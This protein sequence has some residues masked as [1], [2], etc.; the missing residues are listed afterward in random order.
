MDFKEVFNEVTTENG[1]KAFKTTSNALVDFNFKVSSYRE[2]YNDCYITDFRKAFSENPKNAIR[3]LFYLRDV[4]GGIGERK[5]FRDI[6][7]DVLKNHVVDYD[8]ILEIPTYGRWDDLIYLYGKVNMFLDEMVVATI[9]K[10]LD[11]DLNGKPSLLAKWMPSVQGKDR[12]LALKL[13]KALRKTEKQYRKMLSHLRGQINV[14]ERDMSANKW[15]EIDYNK[16]ASRAN[17]KYSHAFLR[18]DEKRRRD[19]LGKVASGEQKINSKTLNLAEIYHMWDYGTANSLWN[20]LEDFTDNSN[21]IVVADV[22][23]SM[24]CGMSGEIQPIDVSKSLAIYFAQH[25]KG[26]YHDQAILFSRY[27]R[28][29]D[30]SGAKTL[31]EYKRIIDKFDEYTNTD[32]EKTFKLILD[33]AVENEVS[34]EEFPNTVLVVSDMEFDS[35]TCADE[36]LFEHL[37]QLYKQ[38]GYKLPRLAFWNVASRKQGI[39]IVENDNGVV[40]VSGYSQSILNQ[41]LNSEV[42]AIKALESV[43]NTDR[44]NNL[45]AYLR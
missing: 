25:S 28:F 10:Q 31:Q 20:S 26:A 34:Q 32:I 13:A 19:F 43:L 27:P 1:A 36:Y 3:Y 15:G 39:P 11:K 7:V 42:S 18:H 40:L 37:K 22:S 29:I 12:K 41:V 24:C 35:C 38:H 44:Y 5:L 14:V 30:F 17:L 8:I 2:G 9:G 21:T 33:Y 16:V 6:L 45:I 4:R 23:G